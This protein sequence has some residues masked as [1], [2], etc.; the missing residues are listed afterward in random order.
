MHRIKLFSIGLTLGFVTLVGCATKPQPPADETASKPEARASSPEDR[1]S[2]ASGTP[3]AT[4][5]AQAPKGP[6][7][8][9]D[10]PPK[11]D[12]ECSKADDS[13][14]LQIEEVHSG[15]WLF[16][17]NRGIKK[18]IAWS[19]RG[20]MHCEKVRDQIRVSLEKGG[21]QCKWN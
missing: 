17:V 13:R 12:I 21:Y 5:A 18:R 10:P 6:R 7:T 8:R 14:V 2:S 9:T 11:P 1:G 4:T 3:A 15:C 19:K 20:N 16:Y